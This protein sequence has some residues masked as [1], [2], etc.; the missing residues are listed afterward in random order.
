MLQLTVSYWILLR[1]YTWIL[2][3]SPTWVKRFY[4]L[5][6]WMQG[7]PLVENWPGAMDGPA[8]TD[9][10]TPP[11]AAAT[12]RWVAVER[13]MLSRVLYANPVC[14]LTTRDPETERRNV[15]TIT[16]LTTINNQVRYQ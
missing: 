5:R 14:L 2:N 8:M 13:G 15:M 16:W 12:G 9:A 3:V 4:K 1:I 7:Y 11:P 10:A 6:I